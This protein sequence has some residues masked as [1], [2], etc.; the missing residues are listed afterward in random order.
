VTGGVTGDV[1]G[2]VTDT[3]RAA[4]LSGRHLV[5][6]ERRRP[7]PEP[8]QL[9]VRVRLAGVAS[10]DLA[11]AT[12]GIPDGTVLGHELVGDVVGVGGGV[13]A[14]GL[15]GIGRRVVALPVQSCGACAACLGGDPVHCPMARIVGTGPG[16][17]GAF[18]ELV[19]VSRHAA[20]PVPDG[21]PD[22]LAVLVEPLAAA[23]RAV[24]RA[25]VGTG[26]RVLVL[27]AGALGVGAAAWAR[28]VGARDVVVSDPLAVRR[29]QALACGATAAVDPAATG[30]AGAYRALGRRR[31][32]VVVECSGTDEALAGAIDVLGRGGRLVVAHLHA[33]A[34]R[35]PLRAAHFKELTVAFS[36]WYEVDDFARTLEAL[37]GGTLHVA[38]VVTHVVG[39]DD[40]PEAYAA[41]RH[42]TDQGKIVVDPRR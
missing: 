5:V 6:G 35:L 18:A 29:E 33:G 32:T 21:V 25:G 42:P 28:V 37:A 19:A 41:L 11:A 31:P 34:V 3:M 24:R 10:T 9:L 4:V 30:T 1:A 8:G 16:A 13:P 38:D 36:A 22:E 14:G 39:L 7:V 17:T 12:A 2:D 26:D 23:L 15:L 27:G 20:L 40:L